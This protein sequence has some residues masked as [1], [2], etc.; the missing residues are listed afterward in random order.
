MLRSTAIHRLI[1]PV[2]LL[3]LFVNVAAQADDGDRIVFVGTDNNIYLLDPYTYV[4]SDITSDAGQSVMYRYPAWSAT[5][6]L[7]FVRYETLSGGRQMAALGRRRDGGTVRYTEDLDGVVPF[8]LYYSP[9]GRYLSALGSMTDRNS[10]GLLLL[11]TDNGA[12]RRVMTGQPFYW[13]WARDG[14]RFLVHSGGMTPLDGVSLY[15]TTEDRVES[16]PLQ[17]GIFQAPAINSNGEVA[18]IAV[19]SAGGGSRIVLSNRDQSVRYSTP[20]V[21]AMH[22]FDWSP[23]EDVLA[24]LSGRPSPIG[25][26]SGRLWLL[27]A[28]DPERTIARDTGIM[29]AGPF[30]WS[31]DGTKIAVFRPS[32]G[33]SGD[34]VVVA[35]AISIHDLETGISREIHTMIP[36]IQFLTQVAPFF[37]QYQRSSTIWSPDSS[38][39]V[40]SAM[41]ENGG[42]GIFILDVDASYQTPDVPDGQQRVLF[43]PGLRVKHLEPLAEGTYPFWSW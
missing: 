34:G 2:V 27:D 5:G 21:D 23:K 9:D 4:V 15:S 29:D 6:E 16:F 14:N 19:S 25:S 35:A 1:W 39:I 33:R 31:P 13:A 26:L 43:V 10:L 12:A 37:D 3:F 20:P 42:P 41:A 24:V 11:P 8:Y 7:A 18:A 30:F 22:A 36:D 28:R 40:I 38:R 17:P 32:I